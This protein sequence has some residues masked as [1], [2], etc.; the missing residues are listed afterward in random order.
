MMIGAMPIIETVNAM[1]IKQNIY[2]PATVVQWTSL[3]EVQFL[4]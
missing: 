3:Q 4:L 1:V 2:L